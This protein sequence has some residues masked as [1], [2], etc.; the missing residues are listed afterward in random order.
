MRAA[1]KKRRKYGMPLSP[2]AFKHPSNPAKLG[3]LSIVDRFSHEL[4]RSVLVAQFYADSETVPLELYDVKILS[5][6]GDTMVLSGT[7]RTN[8]Q[9]TPAEVAQAW[10]C[11]I[12]A[13][14]PEEWK[15]PPISILHAGRLLTV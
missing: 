2:H 8:V 9:G 15:A 7:E 5:L 14:M 12:G 4:K 6:T 3:E 13:M 10:V 1:M 11:K